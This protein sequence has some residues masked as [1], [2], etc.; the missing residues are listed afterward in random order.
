M[1]S[2]L[3]TEAR[4]F[5]FVPGNRPERYDKALA[6]PADMV[7]VDLEDAVPA[8]DKAAARVALAAAWPQWPTAQRARMLVRINA[9]E[10][11][12]HVD[13]LACLAQLPGLPAV[14]LP[15]AEKASDLTGVEAAL[16]TP[17]TALIPIIESAEGLANVDTLTRGPR[18]QRLTFGNLDFQ[19]D[20]GMACGADEAELAPVRVAIVVASR[21]AG[22]AAP[23][24]G[25]TTDTKDM[26]RVQTDAARSLRFGFGAKLCIHPLQ[27]AAVHAAFAPTATQLDWAQ[28]VL[29]AEAAAGGGAFTVDG[30]MVDPPVL[31]L[32][33]QCLAMSLLGK[34]ADATYLSG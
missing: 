31:K 24:D 4:T 3:L 5:L 29:Q 26:A 2:S 33:R 28:R 22:L 13:D 6:S 17:T 34:T 32:A 1:S 15:K 19:A 30:R 11:A 16:G 18:V 23:I 9:A 12:S 25:V 27:V 7:I 21:R 14:M 20:L 8:A 10:T